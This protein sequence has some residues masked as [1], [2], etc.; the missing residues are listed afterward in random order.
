[1]KEAQPEA[2]SPDGSLRGAASPGVGL[3][4]MEV[5]TQQLLYTLPTPG[6]P[7]PVSLAF[8]PCRYQVLGIF[9]TEYV[10]WVRLKCNV[11]Q[12]SYFCQDLGGHQQVGERKVP[13]TGVYFQSGIY[14]EDGNE[15]IAKLSDGSVWS[16]PA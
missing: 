7:T 10:I 14:S 6:L 16:F 13:V 3:A 5:A 9:P 2:L 11:C 4:L 1:M 8:N 12:S 15:V